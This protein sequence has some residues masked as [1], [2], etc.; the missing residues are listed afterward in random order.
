MTDTTQTT[1]SLSE[2]SA[3]ICIA[4]KATTVGKFNVV[5]KILQDFEIALRKKIKIELMNA[6]D[7]M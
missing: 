5:N 7:R 1:S 6:Y 2:T 4:L 3:K